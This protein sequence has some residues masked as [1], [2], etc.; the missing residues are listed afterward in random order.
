MLQLDLSIEAPWPSPPDWEDLALRAAAAL[1][2][3]S[4]ELA[5]PRLQAS[6]LFADDGEVHALNR[7]WRGKDKPTNVLSFPMLE[8]ADLLDLSPA[9]PPELLGDIALALETC[10]RE[11]GEKGIALEAHAVHLIIHGLL[12][13][14]GHDHEL[15]PDEARA[16]EILEIKAL[17]LLGI[18][19]PY[20]DHEAI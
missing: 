1:A 11:A 3:V 15:G 9:G 14:A 10:A 2:R 6:L 4:P 8:R 7:E 17:A 13:L 19:D 18:A 16:M 12:H 5:N 20:G